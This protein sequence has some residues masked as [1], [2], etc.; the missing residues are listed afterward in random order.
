MEPWRRQVRSFV[1]RAGR[2]TAAQARALDELWP[3]YGIDAADGA[4][5]L[6]DL[7]GRHAPRLCEIGF[8]NGDAL[9]TLARDRPDMDFLGIEVHDPGIGHLLLAAE[10]SGLRNLRIARH[11][12][13]EVIRDWLP[14]A[15]LDRV[16]LYFPDPWPKKRHHKRRIVQPAFL[17]AIAQV[18]KPGGVLHMAT[19]WQPYAEQMLRLTEGSGRFRNLAGPGEYSPRPPE[20]P[21]TRFERRGRRLGH[22]V[23]DLVFERVS[24]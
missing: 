21:E 1:R 4:L 20:R 5:D 19:D 22:P 24:P 6:D 14:F 11:D 23:R 2:I 12:A 17:E 9:V 3:I 13:V 18:L 16:H 8:G 10:K 7:F 15:S